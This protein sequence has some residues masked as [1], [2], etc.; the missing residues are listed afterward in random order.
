LRRSD[1]VHEWPSVTQ[2]DSVPLANR[3]LVFHSC[4]TKAVPSRW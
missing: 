2:L 1:H 3:S 4:V